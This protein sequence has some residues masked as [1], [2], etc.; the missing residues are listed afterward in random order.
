MKKADE[1]VRMLRH[2]ELTERAIQLRQAIEKQPGLLASYQ[3]LLTLQKSMVNADQSGDTHRF[4]VARST[5]ETQLADLRSIPIVAEYLNSCE[6]LAELT[7]EITEILNQG[8]QNV[9]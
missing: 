7:T 4:Q 5:Y 3:D 9:K 6:E 1:L 8:L 2:N